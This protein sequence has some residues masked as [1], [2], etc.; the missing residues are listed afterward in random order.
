MSGRLSML[1]T[2]EPQGSILR[3]F[4]YRLA[5]AFP[6]VGTPLHPKSFK[7]DRGRNLLTTLKMPLIN[8]RLTHLFTILLYQPPNRTEKM[9]KSRI[10]VAS[11]IL[12][13][14][15]EG[16]LSV[17]H[18]CP[19]PIPSWVWNPRLYQRWTTVYH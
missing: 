14:N 17:Q 2:Y 1:F 16:R 8:A 10:I 19:T 18:Q 6:W 3:P 9:L 4:A 13:C 7:S 12:F 11:W 5:L 15:Q